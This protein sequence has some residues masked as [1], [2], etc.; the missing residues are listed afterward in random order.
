MTNRMRDFSHPFLV[1]QGLAD[2]VTDPALARAFH[3]LA[4]SEVRRSLIMMMI[5]GS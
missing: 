4:A 5:G 1:L 3:D 2:T